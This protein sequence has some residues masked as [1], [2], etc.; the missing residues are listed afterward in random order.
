M[1]AGIILGV[2]YRREGNPKRLLLWVPVNFVLIEVCSVEIL[3]AGLMISTGLKEDSF[4]ET[5]L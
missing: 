4:R 2:L 3:V 1:E 5:H